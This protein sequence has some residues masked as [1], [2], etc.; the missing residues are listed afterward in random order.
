[1]TLT[2]LLPDTLGAALQAMHG[3]KE[4]QKSVPRKKSS[5]KF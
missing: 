2:I 4:P 3:P 1:M 5:N